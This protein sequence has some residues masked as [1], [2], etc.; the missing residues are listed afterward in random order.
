MRYLAK[1][2]PHNKERWLLR[3]IA[4]A[5]GQREARCDLAE[6]YYFKE[7]WP[8]C[9]AA[10]LSALAI[11]D[12]SLSYL[13]ESDAWTWLPHDYAAIAAYRMGIYGVAL[14]QGRLAVQFAPYNQ[15]LG[16]NLIHYEGATR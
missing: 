1:L 14:E 15:R 9:Y 11:T 8:Q 5:P 7:L 16:E 4:E 2:E 12:K 3:A 6:Y 13:C 10:A